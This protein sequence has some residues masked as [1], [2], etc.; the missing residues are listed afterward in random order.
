MRQ[1]RWMSTLVL[2]ACLIGQ[3]L[4]FRIEESLLAE[5]SDS[6]LTEAQ[7]TGMIAEGFL[8]ETP[9]SNRITKAEAI[10]ASSRWMYLPPRLSA[11][12]A[13]MSVYRHNPGHVH[14]R[15]FDHSADN[16]G[17]PLC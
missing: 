9:L 6:Y 11:D 5:S 13:S 14:A 17:P 12:A 1:L 4:S 8:R 15:F 2:A 7:A 16:R 3:L 10:L